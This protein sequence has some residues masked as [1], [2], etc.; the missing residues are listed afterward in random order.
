L[1][2][3]WIDPL[4]G[5]EAVE[6]SRRIATARSR[7]PMDETNGIQWVIPMESM[8]L[9]GPV[10]RVFDIDAELGN[11]SNTLE[12]QYTWRPWRMESIAKQI[13]AVESNGISTT[14]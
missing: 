9:E 4:E 3:L 12:C 5:I 8:R 6:S 2:G 11:D 13:E 10:S 7:F 1:K 14:S